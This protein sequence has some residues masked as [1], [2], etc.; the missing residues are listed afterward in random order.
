MKSH[1]FTHAK[2]RAL[3]I[4]PDGRTG[5]LVYVSPNSNV[6]KVMVHNRHYRYPL[7]QLKQ[8]EEPTETEGDTQ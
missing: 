8:L 1:A 6:A 7:A 5:R 2:N 3:V 4:T